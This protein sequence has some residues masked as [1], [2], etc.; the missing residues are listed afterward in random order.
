MGESP[1]ILDFKIPETLLEDGSSGSL[2]LLYISRFVSSIVPRGSDDT[3]EFKLYDYQ[4]PLNRDPVRMYF[5]MDSNI[6]LYIRERYVAG[7]VDILS[8]KKL[9][10]WSQQF[11]PDVEDVSA[12]VY[13]QRRKGCIDIDIENGVLVFTDERLT[14]LLPGAG[15]FPSGVSHVEQYT[16]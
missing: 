3:V 7:W 16:G 8:A 5:Y 4:L 2:A 1:L 10:I 14:N 15:W 11:V 6:S 13:I 9:S 12:E